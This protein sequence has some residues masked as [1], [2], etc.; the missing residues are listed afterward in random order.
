M[1]L[2]G[3]RQ[4][5]LLLTLAGCATTVPSPQ[6]SAP[7]VRSAA[8]TPLERDVR[9]LVEQGPRSHAHPE[10][11][12]RIATHLASAFSRAGGLV[13]EQTWEV[14]GHTYRNVVARWGSGDRPLVVVGAHYDA[15]GD[16]PGA[17]D[18]A[19]GV[20]VLL[21]LARRLQDQTPEGPVELVAYS[22][23]EPPYFR[24]EHMGSAVHAASLRAAGTPVRVMLALDSVG[25]FTDV[26]HSQEFPLEFMKAL[27]ST[28]GNTIA[29]I[30][31]T[32]HGDMLRAIRGAYVASTRVKTEALAAPPSL[33]GVD[34]SDHLNYW[35]EGWP[36]VLIT[37]TAFYRND[38][39]H[40]AA[41]TPDTLDYRRMH[42]VAEG[43]ETAVHML[44]RMD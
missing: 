34:F 8:Q 30:G 36:A 26:P 9:W 11:L 32:D 7:E 16:H 38:R 37:D 13:S 43:L 12:D 35:N 19:S 23:E 4:V 27:Y 1:T 25:Y 17:D 15:F 31:R 22:L 24:T 18:N 29:V 28:T 6:Q 5:A 44:A 2:R 33:E 20:A 41:D 14:S 3:G 40:T 39:Y 21:D 10:T 42:E